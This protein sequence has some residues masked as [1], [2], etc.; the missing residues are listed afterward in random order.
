MRA[1]ETHPF[2]IAAVLLLGAVPGCTKSKPPSPDV[3]LPD[4]VAMK[5]D[6]AHLEPR[7]TNLIIVTNAI[8]VVQPS[9]TPTTNN[10]PSVTCAA[11]PSVPC[12]PPDGGQATLTAHVEDADGQ[13]L[14]V[15]WSVD[16]R[17][18][19]AQQVPA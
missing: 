17:E 7:R 9:L 16:G 3:S 12:S 4:P 5:S 11:P 19:Y 10:P 15:T 18:R 13:A 2:W 1:W 14:S 8:T 6:T